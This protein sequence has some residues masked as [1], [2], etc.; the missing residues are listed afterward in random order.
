M[1][2]AI[3]WVWENV[4]GLVI[5]DSQLALGIVVALVVTAAASAFGSSVHPLLGWLLLALLVIVLLANLILTAR[6][7]KRRIA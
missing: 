6:R 2:S 3:A 7:A 5:E 4:V 1:S